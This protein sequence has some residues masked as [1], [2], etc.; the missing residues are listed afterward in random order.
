VTGKIVKRILNGNMDLILSAF[1]EEGGFNW[2][3]SRVDYYI[4]IPC[5]KGKSPGYDKG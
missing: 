5:M 1:G 3:T 2:H 4:Q